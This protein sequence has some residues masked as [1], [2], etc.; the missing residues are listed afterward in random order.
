MFI[1]RQCVEGHEAERPS[2]YQARSSGTDALDDFRK[3]L[4]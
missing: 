4:Q 1:P 2:G 3:G